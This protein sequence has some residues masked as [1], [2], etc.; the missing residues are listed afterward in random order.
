MVSRIRQLILGWTKE[1]QEKGEE[2]IEG[3]HGRA[4]GAHTSGPSLR[5][6][7]VAVGKGTS[8]PTSP[9]FRRPGCSHQRVPARSADKRLSFG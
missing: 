6:L 1:K 7:L 9:A 8:S 5:E 2:A 3:G 4:S